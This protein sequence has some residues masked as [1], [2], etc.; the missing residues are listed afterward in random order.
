VAEGIR[1]NLDNQKK[2]FIE[3]FFST[4]QLV[5][6]GNDTEGLR[7]G[8]IQTPEKYYLTWKCEPHGPMGEP[9]GGNLLDSALVQLCD[10]TRFLELH[11]WLIRVRKRARNKE[12][13]TSGS[14]ILA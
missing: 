6:A 13:A 2:I 9:D 3:R 11:G 7:Y 8:T 1:Q 12:L 5:M 4:M 14:L 10:K